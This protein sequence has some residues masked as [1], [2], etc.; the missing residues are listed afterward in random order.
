MKNTSF[1]TSQ[2]CFP[3]EILCSTKIFVFH[4]KNFFFFKIS[5]FLKFLLLKNLIASLRV[6]NGFW[7]RNYLLVIVDY[8]ETDFSD[9]DLDFFVN[10]PME[11]LCFSVG[12]KRKRKKRKGK[13]KGFQWSLIV[14]KIKLWN[15]HFDCLSWS[16]SSV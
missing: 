6:K 15:F 11:I 8:L 13:P 2:F 9:D 7:K 10:Y 16:I 3:Q 1:I 14:S 5:S 12:K 4:I